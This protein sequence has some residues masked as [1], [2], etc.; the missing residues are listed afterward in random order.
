MMVF[1]RT[2]VMCGP[3]EAMEGIQE[4]EH[5]QAVGL[6]GRSGAQSTVAGERQGR[7]Y[8][9]ASLWNR[10]PATYD[11]RPAAVEW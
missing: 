7:A 2:H 1:L 8:T 9:Y 3:R 5:W 4:I 11:Q 10:A 6:Q